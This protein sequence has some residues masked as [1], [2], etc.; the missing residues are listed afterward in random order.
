MCIGAGD[1]WLANMDHRSCQNYAHHIGCHD[2]GCKRESDANICTIDTD[3]TDE[4]R[5]NARLIAAAPDLLAACKK[6]VECYG[7]P[8][9]GALFGLRAAIAR[10]EGGK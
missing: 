7:D 10:A 1:T 3:I 9:K 6:V 2:E 5:A 8:A 4:Q